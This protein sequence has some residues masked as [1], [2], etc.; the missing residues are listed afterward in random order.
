MIKASTP[1]PGVPAFASAPKWSETADE[2]LGPRFW[3]G[4]KDLPLEPGPRW[5]AP[6][7]ETAGTEQVW[8]PA[9]RPVGL[10]EAP[11]RETKTSNRE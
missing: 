3:L 5:S 6:S 8:R 4:P 1:A 9:T 10:I 2:G 11:E 7:Q